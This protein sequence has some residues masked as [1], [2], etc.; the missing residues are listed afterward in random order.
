[1][2]L[3]RYILVSDEDH[4]LKGNMSDYTFLYKEFKK[5]HVFINHLK[6]KKIFVLFLS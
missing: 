6:Q 5:K 4:T 3:K 2:V 1:M